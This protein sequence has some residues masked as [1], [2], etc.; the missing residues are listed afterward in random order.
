VI[1][2]VL[3]ISTGVSPVDAAAVD[4]WLYVHTDDNTG[5]A[6]NE[7]GTTPFVDAQDEPT[8][9]GWIDSSNKN[10]GNFEVDDTTGTGTV[11]SVNLT[12]YVDSGSERINFWVYDLSATVF[13]EVGFDAGSAGYHYVTIDLISWITT[14]AEIDAIEIYFRSKNQGG[15]GGQVEADYAAIGVNVDIA[16]GTDYDAFIYDSMTFD[17]L[18]SLVVS[19]VSELSETLSFAGSVG[20][21]GSFAKLLFESFVFAD[22]MT[23]SIIIQALLYDSFVVSGTASIAAGYVALL[24]GGIVIQETLSL[25]TLYDLSIYE[26]FVVVADLN[27]QKII[28]LIKNI[29]DSFPVIEVLVVGVTSLA[30][31]MFFQLFLSMNM[32]SY[33]GP[34]AL[35]IGGYFVSQKNANLG[36]IWFMV[37]CLVIAQYL[38]L[39][40]ATPDYWW[41]IF[42]LVIG[43]LLTCVYPL[44]GKK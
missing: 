16:G 26:S 43:G 40:T 5:T 38:V 39:V 23:P 13:V 42:L 4:E 29:Y 3:V 27:A 25:A 34:I 28:Q 24:F 10:W 14:V 11:N 1:G 2:V 9:Y 44:W 21:F 30:G 22:T 36:I 32:W 7:V 20:L 37:E 33:L 8:N 41:H 15:W 12:V 19:F 35:V 18:A 17:E 31:S 6:W